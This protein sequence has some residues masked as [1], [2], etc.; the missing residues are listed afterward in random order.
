MDRA[1]ARGKIERLVGA[2]GENRE[3]YESS[4]YNEAH[5]RSEFIDPFF[6]ALGRDVHNDAHRVGRQREVVVEDRAQVRGHRRRPD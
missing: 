1:A 6:L 5:V 3:H 2:Y 4:E